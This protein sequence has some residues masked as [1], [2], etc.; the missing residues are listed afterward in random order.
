MAQPNSFTCRAREGSDAH[1]RKTTNEDL[2]Q[3][4]LPI[5]LTGGRPEAAQSTHRTSSLPAGLRPPMGG[6]LGTRRTAT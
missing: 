2:D 4:L 3:Q 5:Q 6:R 1:Q